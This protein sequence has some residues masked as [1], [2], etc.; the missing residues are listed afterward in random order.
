MAVLP[1]FW[2]LFPLTAM[3]MNFS[4]PCDYLFYFQVCS[5][6]IR[7]TSKLKQL[8]EEAVGLVLFVLQPVAE[9]VTQIRS[10]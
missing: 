3:R 7:V 5:F 8:S 4:M 10:I 2:A 6:K 9:S 1:A